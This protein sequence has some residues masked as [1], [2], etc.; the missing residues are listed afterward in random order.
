MEILNNEKTVAT[1]AIKH[2]NFFQK[3]HMEEDR[4]NVRRVFPKESKFSN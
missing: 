1:T 3:T 4:N 2:D